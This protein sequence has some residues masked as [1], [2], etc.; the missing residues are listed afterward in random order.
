MAN[1]QLLGSE[2]VLPH[3]ALPESARVL[4]GPAFLYMHLHGASTQGLTSWKPPASI[5]QEGTRADTGT[6]RGTRPQLHSMPGSHHERW[7]APPGQ[8]AVADPGGLCSAR[9]LHQAEA[10][11]RQALRVG[12]P[13]PV[14]T[15]SQQKPQ[16]PAHLLKLLLLTVAQNGFPGS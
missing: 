1:H 7:P 13:C 4:G 3:G 5:T 6:V 9:H 11:G 2:A 10:P 14:H 15:R 8:E 12:A 16:A